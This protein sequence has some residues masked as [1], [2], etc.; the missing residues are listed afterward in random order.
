V[1]KV[2]L[3]TLVPAAVVAV[4]CSDNSAP[5]K[6]AAMTDDLKRDLQL[7]S[8]TQNIQISP[9]EVTPKSHQELALKPKKAPNGPKVIRT[10]HPTVKASATPAQAAEIRTN[11]PQVQV[12][13]SAP[14]PSETPS[15]DAPPMARPSPMPTIN[16]PGAQPIPANG[17]GSVIGAIFGAV[18]RGGIVGDGDDCDPRGMPH[19]GRPIG[20]DIYGRNPMGGVVGGMIGGMGGMRGTGSR[21]RP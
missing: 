3:W 17:G 7:A 15:P 1:R 8:A 21:G 4:A 2:I 18:I 11:I 12:M 14:A 6:K 13:A 20:G 9:D 5:T 16:S 19:G 10:E